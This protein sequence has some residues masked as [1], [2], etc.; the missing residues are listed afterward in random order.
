MFY[1]P[2][3]K[4]TLIGILLLMWANHY[5]SADGQ[6]ARL[7]GQKTQWGRMLDGFAGD[8][9]FFT[10]YAAICLRLMDQPMPFHIGDGMH[11]GIFIWILA[12]FRALFVIV[13][14][15]HWRIIIVIFIYIF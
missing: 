8:I 11:W 7:T 2:D 15:V 9:W 5:D 3:M 6:L 13:N 1:Y 10:I 4:H 14:N 12:A